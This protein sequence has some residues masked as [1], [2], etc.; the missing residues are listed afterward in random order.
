MRITLTKISAS[1]LLALTVDSAQAALYAVDPSP[2]TASNGFFAAWYQDTH[3]RALDL[4]L[5]KAES[6]RAP[7]T[8]MCNLLPNP[9]VFDPTQP[10]SWGTNFPDEAFWFAADTS[11]TDAAAGI[12]LGYV[13]AVEAAF[14]SGLPAEND[15]VSFARIRIRVDVPAA[16][17][18][19]VTHP[20]GVEVFTVDTPGIKAI[21]LTR[22]IGIGSAGDFTGALKGDVGPFLRSK[23][24]PY[25]EPDPQ[26]GTLD[27]FIGDPNIL[28]EVTGSPFGTNFVRIEG[29]NGI[30]AETKLFAVTGKLSSVP[31]PTPLLVERTTYS[32]G[33]DQGTTQQDIFVLAP[34]PLGTASFDAT[35]M[36]GTELGAWY[37]QSSQV[38]TGSV[39]ITADNSQ[40]I[41]GSTPTTKTSPLVDLVT[42]SRA[43]YSLAT[44]TLTVE[45]ASS[46]TSAQQGLSID[47]IIGPF[48][49]GR[50]QQQVLPIPPAHV[51][52]ISANGGSD[53]EEVHILP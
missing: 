2:P 27:T 19:T 15:Q 5:S 21:N 52:V 46:D 1:L 31:L 38:G 44:S 9:G 24:G 35:P 4:C 45:A 33:G 51:T 13:S 25:Q 22:D 29:P 34:P 16:G 37:G 48:I 32:R 39:S 8:F 12:D 7:G 47:G 30:R 40:V 17:T 43:E 28:E 50:L 11:I 14:G 42:I 23:N 3:G 6:R 53:T 26:A 41:A 20:Y 49:D 18:Y 36:R 10:V